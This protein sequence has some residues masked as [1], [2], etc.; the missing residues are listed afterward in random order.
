MA[1]NTGCKVISVERIATWWIRWEDLEWPGG[2]VSE[3]IKRRAGAFAEAQVSAAMI[4]GA[5]F[6]WDFLPLFTQLNDYIAFVAEELHKYGIKLFDHHSVTLTHRYRTKEQLRRIMLDSAPHLPLCPSFEAAESW[7]YKGT[8]LNDW[9]M[10]DVRDYK[11][12]YLPQYMAES[13]CYRNPG[14]ISAYTDYAARLVRDTGIDGLSADDTVHM[15][16]YISCG[17]EYCRAELNR[18]SGT[19]LP[20]AGDNSFWGNWD[21]PAWRDWI[22]LRFDAAGEFFRRLKAAL[23]EG[24]MLTAC[25]GASAS[26]YSVAAASDARQFI[27]GCNYVNMELVGNTPPYKHDPLTVNVPMRQRFTNSSHHYAVARGAGTRF[28]NTGFA[29]SAVSADCVWAICKAMGGDAWIGTLKSRLG[30]PRRVLDTLPNEEDIV[31]IAFGFEKAHPE[32]FEGELLAGVG[33]YFSYETRNHTLFGSLFSGYCEDYNQTLA[34]LFRH[35]VCAHTLFEFPENTEEYA[36]VLLP[37]AARMSA[38]ETK[39]MDKYIAAGGT[40]IV[41]GPSAVPGCESGRVL[42]NRVDV[43]EGEFFPS[44]PDGVHLRS[45]AWLKAKLPAGGEGGWSSPRRGLYYH[46][47]RASEGRDEEELIKLCREAVLPSPVRV[48]PAKGFLTTVF[49]SDKYFIAHLLAEEYDVEI[50]RELD[51]VRTHRSR[52]NII[53][54]AEPAGTDGEIRIQTHL[55]LRAYAPFS[56][57]GPVIMPGADGYTVRLPECCAYAI[58]R[59]DKQV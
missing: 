10:L 27:R 16:G 43:P 9:R 29:H 50:D 44:V 25:G 21:N 2:D 31:N 47:A 38:E 6:R 28:F 52:V 56:D 32:L 22:D 19:E 30:L 54:K 17:C 51:A 58:L 26:G 45:P 14:F 36:E 49:E 8:L 11:P 39:A 48:L 59:F 7:R 3:R 34:L 57:D 42:P 41:T 12:V 13:F 53:T 18:R 5:H 24:F 1:S 4:F 40:V 46:P 20:P 35:A 55:P 23:P 37:S 15:G 33:V